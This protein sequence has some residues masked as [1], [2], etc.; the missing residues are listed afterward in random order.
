MGLF[1]FSANDQVVGLV[2]DKA[3]DAATERRLQRVGWLRAVTVED[4]HT[5]LLCILVVEG[6]CDLVAFKRPHSEHRPRGI[7]WVSVRRLA[8]I[9]RRATRDREIALSAEV[10]ESWQDFYF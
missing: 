1:I 9:A 10:T 7:R 6:E 8:V 2:G 3:R 5:V 4:F